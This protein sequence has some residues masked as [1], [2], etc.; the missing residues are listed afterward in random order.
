MLANSSIYF[1]I[2]AGL[3]GT[4][5]FEGLS[6]NERENIIYV[7]GRLIDGSTHSISRTF[8]TGRI[9]LKGLC[10]CKCLVI[11]SKHAIKMVH[12]YL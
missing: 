12:F 9:H 1:I 4:A 11:L 2:N 8:A 3:D 10:V 6:V 5:S 7:E